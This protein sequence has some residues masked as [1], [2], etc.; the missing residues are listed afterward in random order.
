MGTLVVLS[1]KRTLRLRYLLGAFAKLVRGSADIDVP[2]VLRELASGFGG[3]FAVSRSDALSQQVT[4]RVPRA[5]V[6]SNAA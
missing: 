6:I 5:F 2:A 1:R 3:E 4:L